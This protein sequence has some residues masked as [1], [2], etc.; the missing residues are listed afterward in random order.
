MDKL[1]IK[2]ESEVLDTEEK[3]KL[4]EDEYGVK[5]IGDFCVKNTL[6]GWANIPVAVFY[7]E[8]P[9]TE[10]GHS[11]YM[12]LYWKSLTGDLMI[13][14]AESAFSVPISGFIDDDGYFTYSSHRW[15]YASGIQDG[16]PVAVDGARD[17]IRVVG[18]PKLLRARINKD[19]LEKI[20]D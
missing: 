1:T 17:Y 9:K 13:T 7:Q 6:G 10:L 18:D 16:K 5:F 8:S 2:R 14:N 11:H 4:I 20:N 12:G 3:I 19:H 15:H